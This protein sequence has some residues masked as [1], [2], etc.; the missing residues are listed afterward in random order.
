[1]RR[2]RCLCTHLAA[3]YRDHIPPPLWC[4]S[5]GRKQR[6]SH[7]VTDVCSEGTVPEGW[8]LARREPLFPK[9]AEIRVLCVTRSTPRASVR[10]V[11]G[12]RVSGS[13]GVHWV[14]GPPVELATVPRSCDPAVPRQYVSDLRSSRPRHVLCRVDTTPRSRSVGIRFTG[15]VK[16][17]FCR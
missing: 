14:F 3:R 12:H 10:C 17:T 9:V 5:R 2:S 6:R 1:M 11:P 13:G 15:G 7:C 16:R 4:C 8:A